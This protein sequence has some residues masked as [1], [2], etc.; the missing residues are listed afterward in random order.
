[1]P[2]KGTVAADRASRHRGARQR[3]VPQRPDASGRATARRAARVSSGGSIPATILESWRSIPAS[4]AILRGFLGVTFTYAGIQKL[5]DPNFLH[6]GSADFIGRQ[7]QGFAQGSPIGGVLTLLAQAPVLAGVVIAVSEIAVGL[8]TLLGVAPLLFAVG[9]FLINVALTLSA[10]WH[11]HPYFLGSD[12]VYA[13]AWVAYAAGIVEMRRRASRGSHGRSLVARTGEIG[14][15]EVLRGGVLAGV[16]LLAAGAATA[17][18]GKTAPS[19]GGLSARASDSTSSGAGTASGGSAP[20]ATTPDAQ[21]TPIANL[22]QINV[23]GAV[24]FNDPGSGPAV[25]VRTGR[26]QVEAY[27]RV[28]THAGCLVGYD[29]SSQILFCPCHGAEYDPSRGAA[30]IA[31]PAP[32][33]LSRIDVVVDPTSGDVTIPR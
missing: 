18:T 25:L 8:G 31:G 28:C 30:V 10:T 15:R 24:G 32:A 3:A 17:L 26:N 9:G 2:E 11:V 12:S 21:G 23:G 6:A 29:P 33:P 7:L 13:I 27:S 4:L 14:R 5:L 16:T 1:M 22:D 20:L 19:S